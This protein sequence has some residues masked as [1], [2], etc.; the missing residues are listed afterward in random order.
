M[1]LLL[2]LFPAAGACLIALSHFPTIPVFSQLHI[3]FYFFRTRTMKR[4]A[5]IR[6]LSVL[7][8]RIRHRSSQEAMFVGKLKSFFPSV[9]DTA[10]MPNP[11]EDSSSRMSV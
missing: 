11:R 4:T 9:V 10:Q 6:R 7:R 2:A 8:S 5:S 3:R 1:R